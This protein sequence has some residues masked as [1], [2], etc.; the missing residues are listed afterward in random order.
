MVSKY[1]EIQHSVLMSRYPSL[2]EC[3]TVII[4]LSFRLNMSFGL[5]RTVSFFNKT[6]CNRQFIFPNPIIENSTFLRGGLFHT[7]R[8]TISKIKKHAPLLFLIRTLVK[9]VYHKTN[10]LISQSNHMLWVLKRTVS[11]AKIDR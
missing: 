5:K 6:F 11:Y 10:F 8:E 9:S 4:F 3:K 7:E 2:L 1:A